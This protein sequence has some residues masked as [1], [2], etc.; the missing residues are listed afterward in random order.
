[1]ED[2]QFDH[3]AK[4]FG[5]VVTRRLTLGALL[6]GALARLGLGEAAAKKGGKVARAE[7]TNCKIILACGTCQSFKKGRAIRRNGRKLCKKGKC[8]P[9]SG[10]RCTA[11]T[12]GAGICQ[13]GTC[14]PAGPQCT[15]GSTNCSGVCTN[16]QTDEQN[17]G[18]CGHDCTSLFP[19]CC[20]GTCQFI[21]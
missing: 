6:V 13:N 7:S 1:M 4:S 21:C 10:T 8:Q 3:L 11:S 18:S 17:C 19:I 9:L 5:T 12:G 16:L 20:S 14:V 15:G 2:T